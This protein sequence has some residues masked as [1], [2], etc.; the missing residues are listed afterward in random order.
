MQYIVDVGST[1]P[2]QE[3]ESFS[4]TP[5]VVIGMVMAT[6]QFAECQSTDFESLVRAALPAELIIYV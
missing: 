3:A 4:Y 5:Y 2:F 6:G 1:I